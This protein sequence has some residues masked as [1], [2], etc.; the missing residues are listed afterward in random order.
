M[1]RC[2]QHFGDRKDDSHSVREFLF[3]EKSVSKKDITWARFFVCVYLDQFNDHAEEFWGF[4]GDG[5]S[6]R[7]AEYC[8]E[9]LPFMDSESSDSLISTF[10]D[11][12]LTAGPDA[13]PW[14]ES[15]PDV[16][17]RIKKMIA[18]CVTSQNPNYESVRSEDVFL[19][20][21]GM[22]AIGA[23]ARALVPVSSHSS[24]AVIFG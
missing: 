6:S 23:V 22:C 7:H 1:R 17:L 4:Q 2:S 19:Y 9:R 16:K 13:E 14:T 20:P 24:E 21:K 3:S 10:A 5:I 11:S 15:A 12:D 18:E 8:L